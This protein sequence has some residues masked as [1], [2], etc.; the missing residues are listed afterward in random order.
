MTTIATL[1]AVLGLDATA[2]NAGI[3]GAQAKA[4][5]LG[6][7]FGGLGPGT[8][9]IAAVGV[10]ALGTGVA[11]GGAISIAAEFEQQIDAVGAVTQASAAEIDAL[12][13]KAL[14]LGADTQYG[15]TE[16][17]RAMEILAMN[18]LTTTQILNGA[19]DAAA[20]LAAAGGT[21]LAQ[22]ADTVSTSMAIW[23]LKTEDL[24][25]VTNMLAGAANVS[26]F[27]VEDMAYAIAM[28]GGAAAVAGVSFEDFATTIAAIA[29]SFS[30]GSDA[31]TSLKTMLMRLMPQTKKAREE[32]SELGLIA[33]NGLPVW[34]DSAGAFKGMAAVADALQ[35]KLG[36]L[37]EAQKI[38]ALHTLFGTDAMR[39]AAGMMGLGGEA[40][41]ELQRKMIA[42]D[43]AAIAAQRMGNLKGA[44]ELLKGA[45][46]SMAIETGTK[47]LPVLTTMVLFLAEHLPL[48]F[49]KVH[50]VVD[51][52]IAK[53]MELA[54]AVDPEIWQA[55]AVGIGTVLVV[56]FLAWAV[57]AAVAAVATLAA[58]WPLLLI[59]AVIA[60]VG[61]GVFLLIKHWD[62]LTARFPILA[63]AAER[64]RAVLE[65]MAAW[66]TGT[67]IPKLME[68]GQRIVEAWP[69][70]VAAIQGAMEDIKAV[71]DRVWPVLVTIV[72]GA[73]NG[74]K[75]IVHAVWPEI[76][77]FI[78]TNVQGIVDVFTTNW[79]LIQE[80]VRAGMELI[81]TIFDVAWPHIKSVTSDAMS[82]I[83]AVVSFLMPAITG[84][85]EGGMILIQGVWTAGWTVLSGIAEGVWQV[86]GGVIEG[87]LTVILGIIRLATAV[88][89]GDWEGAWDAI[90]LIVQGVWI[91]I[92]GVVSGS[93]TI[94]GAI[95][96][97]GLILIKAVWEATWEAIK[98]VM[99][100]VW[101]AIQL[102]AGAA[103]GFLLGIVESIGGQIK[104]AFDNIKDKVEAVG[105]AFTS[106]LG[107][108]GGAVVSLRDTIMGPINT[109]IELV[110]KLLG[111]IAQIPTS[112]KLP[113]MP[114]GDLI[115]GA[116]GKIPGLAGGGL[117]TGPPSGHLAMLHG[118][119]AVI[120]LDRLDKMMDR[121]GGRGITL[122]IT[123]P[124]YGIDDLTNQIDSGLKRAGLAGIR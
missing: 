44:I 73:T 100:V 86:I 57:A 65:A 53:L 74:I 83:H 116:V 62:E 12:G 61:A 123:G 119:E 91:T 54:R 70:I 11:L 41:N 82:A 68:I 3:A 49:A 18:G 108:A 87:G 106:A 102:A 17:A 75:A 9:A 51:P 99:Q 29:P 50:A 15:A 55:A 118:T 69:A 121:K 98:G 26:R 45:L 23:G 120:P 30:S 34:Y 90:K 42:T 60:L 33:A 92:E 114:G 48:A 31:G 94:I 59:I 6:G 64:V 112:I 46:E 107:A 85:I 76:K 84:F 103:L 88:L 122:N 111:L 52:F 81:R 117:V 124:V 37:S 16:I 79:P 80:V 67:L 110:E 105:G 35:A 21:T 25:N 20:A 115:S 71:F 77:N 5:M 96:S 10:A 7:A 95:I 13:D 47:F 2:F 4:G 39:A 14:Q 22:A 40:F 43:A 1:I 66:I 19:A 104:T 72:E 89:K 56:A 97:G 24:A 58:M 113:D 93:L 28:G 101:D 27:G 8:L 109:I 78:M 36:P 38:Q 63:T 32:M